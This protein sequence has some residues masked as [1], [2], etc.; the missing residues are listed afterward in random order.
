MTN[1]RCQTPM[2]KRAAAGERSAV[3]ASRSCAPIGTQSA[4]RPKTVSDTGFPLRGPAELDWWRERPGGAEWL[5][6]LP[7]L[8][9]D[10]ARR[11]RLELGVPMS[12]DHVS[13]ALPARLADGTKAVL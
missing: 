11:W 1:N 10:T 6:R 9:A 5:A 3:Q 12:R 4:Q 2:L 13:L 8:A 7:A